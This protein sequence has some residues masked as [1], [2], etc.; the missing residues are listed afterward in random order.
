MT[1]AKGKEG[2]SEKIGLHNLA[3]AL[4]FAF[5]PIT[6]SPSLQRSS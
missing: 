4:A 1:P 2:S 3:A 5:T 6:S